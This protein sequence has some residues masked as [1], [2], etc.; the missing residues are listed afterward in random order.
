MYKNGQATTVGVS[1]TAWPLIPA[2]G[3]QERQAEN[4]RLQ[5]GKDVWLVEVLDFEKFTEKANLLAFAPTEQLHSLPLHAL[6]Y[7]D[8]VRS[9]CLRAGRYGCI[10]GMQV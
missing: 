1:T 2:R 9:A 10:L 8:G 5:S 7:C 3:C 6:S 4:R